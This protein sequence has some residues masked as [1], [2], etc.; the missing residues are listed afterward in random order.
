[1]G[2]IKK[3]LSSYFT[4]QKIFEEI[5]DRSQ[6]GI[7]LGNIGNI[8]FVTQNSD[9]ANIYYNKQL[10]I[11][12][13]INKLSG[14]ATSYGSLGRIFASKGDYKRALEYYRKQYHIN[15]LLKIEDSISTSFG[16]IGKLYFDIGKYKKSINYFTKQYK[17]SLSISKKDEILSSLLNL[18][19]ANTLINNYKEAIKFYDKALSL[20]KNNVMNLDAFN[21]YLNYCELLI[22]LKQYKKAFIYC[23]KVISLKK[24]CSDV[25]LI[26]IAKIIF[27][28]IKILHL[29]NTLN[30]QKRY[31]SKELNYNFT[32]AIDKVEFY[33]KKL[34]G[35]EYIAD[36]YYVLNEIVYYAK[37]SNIRVKKELEI[38]KKA[39]DLHKE[40]LLR[41]PNSIYKLQLKAI[42]EDKFS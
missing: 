11:F 18:G 13:S 4:S 2:L 23:N 33:S 17:I 30:L 6:L 34:S 32:N 26:L 42:I 28:K 8:H 22:K 36:A 39:I 15:R 35:E 37:M 41:I 1:M 14:I 12:K 25:D 20:I 21:L 5:G 10:N 29:L 24:H 3:S 9:L 7:T 16:N 40:L 19:G 27:Q 31:E 38:K